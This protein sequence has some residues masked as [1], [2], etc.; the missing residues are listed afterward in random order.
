MVFI[1]FEPVGPIRRATLQSAGVPLQCR[2]TAESRS[3]K[4]EFRIRTS[5]LC[6][7]LEEG[8]WRRIPGGVMQPRTFRMAR[9]DP[10]RQGVMNERS[11][12]RG[13]ISF[14]PK[15]DDKVQKRLQTT[16]NPIPPSIPPVF[17]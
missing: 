2:L 9:I 8:S 11:F 13:D 1:T 15:N 6:A 10:S 5:Q 12:I 17:P 4:P 3:S 14:Y 7:A 16:K